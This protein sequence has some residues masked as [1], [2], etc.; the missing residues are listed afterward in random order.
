MKAITIDPQDHLIITESPSMV[1]PPHW[2]RIRVKAS[3][4]NRADLLQRAGRYP[5]PAG[6]SEILG[7]EVAGEIACDCGPWRCGQRVMALLDGGGYASEVRVPPGQVMAL[8]DNLSFEQGAAIPEAFLTAYQALFALAGLRAGETVLIHAGASGVGSAA[9]QLAHYADARVVVTCSSEAKAEYCRQL[10]AHLAINYRSGPW[11]ETCPGVDVVLDVVGGDYLKGNLKVMNC[12]ARLV[13]LSML[14]GRY[15]E[16]DFAQL[17]SKRI[18]MMGSTL[19]NRS[20]AYKSSLISN[21]EAEFGAALAEGEVRA[22]VDTVYPWEQVET[23]HR[24]M[25]NNQNCGKL[26]LSLE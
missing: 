11:A 15:G 2:P 22:T 13:T 26:V 5:P 25:A 16:L 4:V 21:F 23:A 3:G 10:G 18:T 7:L 14:G 19:R 8:A 24:R 6:A 12:D 17:L 20:E 1:A 9:I